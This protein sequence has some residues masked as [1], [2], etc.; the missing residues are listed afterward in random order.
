MIGRT[1]FP[2]SG[3]GSVVVVNEG[4]YVVNA[5]NVFIPRWRTRVYIGSFT[6]SLKATYVSGKKKRT[7][8]CTFPRFGTEKKVSSSRKW[9]WYSPPRGCTLP[10]ELVTQLAQGKTTMQFTGSFTRKWATTGK[11]TRPDGSRIQKLTI[12]LVIA[13]SESVALN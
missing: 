8:T 1:P 3:V 7:Y 12:S 4:G 10:K 11:T 6:F 5:R 2:I 9:R 13:G